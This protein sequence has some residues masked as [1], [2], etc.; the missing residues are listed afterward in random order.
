MA[1]ETESITIESGQ[2]L[3]GIATQQGTTISKLLELNPN[4][5]DPNL[6]FAGAPLIIPG[7]QPA[8]QTV[9]ATDMTDKN[10]EVVDA[11]NDAP[12]ASTS[13]ADTLLGAGNAEAAGA[14]DFQST[15]LSLF[16]TIKKEREE[17]Q[18]QQDSLLSKITNRETTSAEDLR[19]Q[20]FAELGL[21][22][23]FT[24]ESFQ[25]LQTIQGEVAVL[26][27]KLNV[28]NAREQQALLVEEGQRIPDRIIRGRQALIA[29]QFA[30]ERSALAAEIGAKT[31]QAES[32]KGNLQLANNLASQTVEAMLFDIKQ[33]R[34]DLEFLF[35]FR[36]DIVSG[37]Q[38][39]ERNLLNTALQSLKDDE[40]NQRE[41]L[42]QKMALLREAASNGIDLGIST[43]QL[44]SMSLEEVNEKFVSKVQKQEQAGIAGDLF[45][46][47][48]QAGREV[49]LRLQSVGISGEFLNHIT[50]GVAEFGLDAVIESEDLTP[51]Q[52]SA[53]REAYGAERQ[54]LTRDFFKSLFT[55]EAL[56]AAAAEAGFGD[57][58]E[59]IFNLKDVDVEKYLDSVEANIEAYR[60]AG[61][62]DQAI[63][64]L[65]QK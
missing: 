15:I 16:E 29:R 7:A 33:E 32:L 10:T 56:E 51:G 60:Q 45:S 1:T 55:T 50:Q 17:A 46:T 25:Q 35:N 11:L 41:D 52:E 28:L 43:D 49:L 54:F 59:G 3:S 34:S 26:T 53:L 40:Q 19:K 8:S 23:N 38:Q 6:I 63:L 57:L 2:T 64:K 14:E 58:G 21:P 37:L 47:D 24:K 18:K 44:K 61:L 42:S 48:T 13:V 20:A 30:A 27:D 12:T 62:T 22:E 39:D 5:K 4:I 9:S 65:M 36:S 31:M